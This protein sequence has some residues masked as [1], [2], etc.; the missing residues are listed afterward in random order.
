MLNS[1]FTEI[2]IKTYKTGVIIMNRTR[3]TDYSN[4]LF[5][6]LGYT[7][8]NLIVDSMFILIRN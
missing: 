2:F 3:S 4:K 7:L 5:V 6:Y 1:S 8:S